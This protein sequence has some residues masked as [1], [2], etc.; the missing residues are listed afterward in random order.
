MN[1]S[2]CLAILLH[3]EK[4]RQTEIVRMCRRQ[5]LRALCRTG[6]C[7]SAFPTTLLGFFSRFP[8]LRRFMGTKIA[9]FSTAVDDNEMKIALSS[10]QMTIQEF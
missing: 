4:C 10:A 9:L 1:A 2:L 5:Y 3:Q 6:V 7:D 8:G